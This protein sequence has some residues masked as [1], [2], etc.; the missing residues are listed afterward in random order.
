MFKC[1]F[2]GASKIRVIFGGWGL[3]SGKTY[4]F[5]FVDLLDFATLSS[6]NSLK[7]VKASQ[8]PSPPNILVFPLQRAA[9]HGLVV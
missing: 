6:V 7:H 9:V 2:L 8:T 4:I 5:G 1:N 3:D